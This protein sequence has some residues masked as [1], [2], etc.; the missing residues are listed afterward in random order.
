VSV[1]DLELAAA[2]ASLGAPTLQ[3]A[4]LAALADLHPEP[5]CRIC[6]NALA[7]RDCDLGTHAQCDPPVVRGPMPDRHSN[8][9]PPR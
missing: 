4:A 7:D 5:V 9:C 3:D 8:R 6:M 1:S 2:L